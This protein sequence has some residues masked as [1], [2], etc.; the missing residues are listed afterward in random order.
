MLLGF[1]MLRQL[2][3]ARHSVRSMYSINAGRATTRVRHIRHIGKVPLVGA[4]PSSGRH[5]YLVG[6]QILA[7]TN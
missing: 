1:D 3:Q 5:I 4:L 2:I 7:S 6:L